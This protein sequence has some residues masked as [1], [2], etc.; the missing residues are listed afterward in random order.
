M[1]R[2]LLGARAALAIVGPEEQ[3][4][5]E[6]VA[7]AAFSAAS[8]VALLARPFSPVHWAAVERQH[9]HRADIDTDAAVDADGVPVVEGLLVLCERHDVDA[10]LAVCGVLCAGRD[11]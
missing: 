4:K 10:D 8:S 1:R 11:R 7:V 2:P 5:R 3:K 6:P 9:V